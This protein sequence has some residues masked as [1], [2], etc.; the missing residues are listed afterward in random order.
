MYY[1]NMQLSDEEIVKLV[2]SGKI[3]EFS[4]IV[5]RY[6]RKLLRYVR[7]IIN[8]TTDSEDIVQDT[9]IRAY[10]NLQGFNQK[11]KFSSWIYRIAH[12]QAVNYIRK[13]RP[14]YFNRDDWQKYESINYNHL[15]NHTQKIISKHDLA[16][17]LSRL[18]M[19]YKEPVELY[20]IEGYTYSQISDILRLPQ[21][22]VGTRIH[23]AIKLLRYNN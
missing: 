17:L 11:L 16:L 13:K 18:P 3:Q 5:E 4:E 22:T 9:F 20:Y 2:C 23:R 8:G 14:V 7:F 19:K 1:M 10:Q 21:G 12:N 6:Q 15:P